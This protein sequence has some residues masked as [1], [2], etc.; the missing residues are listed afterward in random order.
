VDGF[1]WNYASLTPL[2]A[3]LYEATVAGTSAAS[4]PVWPTVVAGTVVDGGVTWTA[5]A[6]SRVTWKAVPIMKS[7]TVEPVWP[8]SPGASVLDGTISWRATTRAVE[9]SG[10][11]HTK[12]VIIAKS[13]VWAV[14][15]NGDVVKFCA[16][17]AP[18]D[19]SSPNDAGFLPTGMN[20]QGSETATLLGI[21]RAK[22]VV[23][24]A[25][26]IQLWDIDEDPANNALFDT[27]EGIGSIY[28]RAGIS[29]GNEYYFLPPLGVRTI[30]IA[31]GATNFQ[32]GDVG[33][34]IDDLIQGY[35]AYL[36]PAT[37]EP[38]SLYW[39][40]GGQYWL[41]FPPAAGQTDA[42]VFVFTM[43]RI[44]SVGAWSRYIFPFQIKWRSLLNNDLFVRDA[45]CSWRVNPQINYDEIAN[46]TP[47]PTKR[48]YDGIV[49]W[50]WL[51]MGS[52]GQDSTMEGFDIVGNGEATVQ[53]GY[54]QRNQGTFT[55]AY[56]VDE[57]TLTGQP[58]P[59]QLTAPS[60]S[61]KITYVGEFG[62]FWELK[63]FVM[64]FT[65]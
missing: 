29:V 28:N 44:G 18:K 25:S 35:M 1:T 53:F 47:S 39:P 7:G 64:Y 24:T 17:F 46:G 54:D 5:R 26:G 41:A 57:D 51:D 33:A 36:T 4:E 59:L 55:D 6:A 11:P 13:K 2:G 23:G 50:P 32:A 48:Y 10:C 56:V 9:D 65:N 43:N 31:A 12:V 8:T 22:L 14:G 16:T 49:Q 20:Q 34:P 52:P 19:W 3:F 42:T 61:P 37:P 60:I 63:A 40:G 15:I 21:Y 62:K 30:G 27:I 38:L 58:I 45:T